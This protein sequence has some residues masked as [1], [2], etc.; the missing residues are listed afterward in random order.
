MV[1]GAMSC[2][3]WGGGAGASGGGGAGGRIVSSLTETWFFARF[4]GP[5]RGPGGTDLHPSKTP[6]E[7]Q[8]K[9]PRRA[10]FNLLFLLSKFALK[11]PSGKARNWPQKQPLNQA[12]RAP[13]SPSSTWAA[14][15]ST[16]TPATSPASSSRIPG[17]WRRSAPR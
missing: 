16:G 15:C 1:I 11:T 5:A 7:D 10:D 14:C 9:T 3:G 4:Y 6:P 17:K 12:L 13:R 2:G 8:Q